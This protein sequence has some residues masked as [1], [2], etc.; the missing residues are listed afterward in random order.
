MIESVSVGNIFTQLKVF[1]VITLILKVNEFDDDDG[2]DEDDGAGASTSVD[3][4]QQTG[5]MIS[6]IDPIS[7]GPL[8]NPVRN[9]I[10]GHIYGR[11]TVLQSLQ[12]NRNLR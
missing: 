7:K 9:S 10:C 6:D 2:S 12:M 4:I 1:N 11:N 5:S 8:E 3:E